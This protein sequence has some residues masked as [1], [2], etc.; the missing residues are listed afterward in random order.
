MEC[1]TP[2]EVQNL[3]DCKYSMFIKCP[4]KNRDSKV[5]ARCL[6][7][8]LF[9]ALDHAFISLATANLDALIELL[10]DQKLL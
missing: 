6:V 2:K 9:Y 7:M 10:K 4:E 8:G 5:C 3:P 1:L